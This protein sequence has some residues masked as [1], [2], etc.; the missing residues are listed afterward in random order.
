MWL[1]QIV[2]HRI[3]N[4]VRR[5][6]HTA[7]RGVAQEVSSP[8][9]LGPDQN[10]GP[11]P[12]ASVLAMAK[13]LHRAVEDAITRLPGDYRLVLRLVEKE[14]FTMAQAGERM[15]RSANAAKKLYGRAVAR[16]RSLLAER[17][18]KRDV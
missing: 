7:K 13:E 2:E 6:V 18:P 8:N 12:T 1:D 14:G 5:Y 16:L 9:L 10:V 3:G 4:V 15:G 11:D 17:E